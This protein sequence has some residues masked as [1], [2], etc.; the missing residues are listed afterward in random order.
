[1]QFLSEGKANVLF[2]S[3]CLFIRVPQVS[4][5]V[6]L[7]PSSVLATLLLFWPFIVNEDDL[8][9]QCFEAMFFV[10]HQYIGLTE[11]LFQK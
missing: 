5:Y 8:Q 4:A 9:R 7:P 1:M 2:F 10:I 6:A 11:C 3:R